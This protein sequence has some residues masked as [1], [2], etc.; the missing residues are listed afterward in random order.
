M[1]GTLKFTYRKKLWEKYK[2]TPIIRLMLTRNQ[3]ESKNC[4]NTP[5][6]NGYPDLHPK[7]VE[8]YSSRKSITHYKKTTL[9]SIKATCKE[10]IKYIAKETSFKS[11]QLEFE[12]DFFKTDPIN[13]PD[14]EENLREKGIYTGGKLIITEVEES[15]HM[16]EFKYP[17]FQEEL[18]DDVGDDDFPNYL[19]EED[20]EIIDKENELIKKEEIRKKG[21]E[22]EFENYNNKCKETKEF[23][24]CESLTSKK[25]SVELEQIL[26]SYKFE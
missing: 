3:K 6:K 26:T 17:I 25:I 12:K 24:T 18:F 10:L 11:F 21:L 15:K 22:D 2:G 16:G 19:I 14:T 4:L 5:Y 23:N 7:L 13:I 9:I 8:I 20:K 1:Y